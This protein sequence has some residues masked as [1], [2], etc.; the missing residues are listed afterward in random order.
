MEIVITTFLERDAVFFVTRRKAQRDKGD[1][2]ILLGENTGDG[3]VVLRQITFH[4]TD[5][6]IS[7]VLL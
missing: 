7:T 2:R 4:C 3:A 6:W 1:G 5:V